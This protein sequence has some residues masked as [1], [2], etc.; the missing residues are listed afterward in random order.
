MYGN[1]WG[2][3]VCLKQNCARISCGHMHQIFASSSTTLGIF[4]SVVIFDQPIILA[5]VE[6]QL[7]DKKSQAAWKPNFWVK[8]WSSYNY[9]QVVTPLYWKSAVLYA[10]IILNQIQITQLFISI[11][12][13]CTM[14]YSVHTDIE[15][16]SYLTPVVVVE[17]PWKFWIIYWRLINF[18]QSYIW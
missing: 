15:V 18:A 8:V 11:W 2:R 16:R 9:M 1:L 6:P 4:I 3:Y 5:E 13:I 17:Y 14:L 12:G 7:A 10:T